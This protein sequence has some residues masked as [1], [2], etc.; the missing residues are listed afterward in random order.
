MDFPTHLKST[1]KK[2]R[3]NISYNPFKKTDTAPKNM[4]DWIAA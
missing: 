4:T 1:I 3:L 2:W